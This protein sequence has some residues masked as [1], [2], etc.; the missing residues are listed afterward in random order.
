MNWLNSLCCFG[1][2]MSKSNSVPI[3]LYHVV[4]RQNTIYEEALVHI[5]ES[6]TQDGLVARLALQMVKR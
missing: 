6:D 5:A 2:H 3:T 1:D 4:V